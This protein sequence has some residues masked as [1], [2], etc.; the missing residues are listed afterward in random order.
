MFW[1]LGNSEQKEQMMEHDQN[2]SDRTALRTH[3]RRKDGV[4]YKLRVVD[5]T[6]GMLELVEVPP[7]R[8]WFEEWTRVMHITGWSI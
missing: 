5:G 3:T 4:Q 8:T 7:P 2:L 1:N 6:G